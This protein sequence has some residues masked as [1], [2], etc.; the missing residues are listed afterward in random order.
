MAGEWDEKRRE[1]SQNCEGD[2]KKV[3]GYKESY[4]EGEK[5]A[6]RSEYKQKKAIGGLLVGRGRVRK[7]EWHW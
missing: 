3:K 2:Q 7:E 6:E 5:E 1:K 4:S